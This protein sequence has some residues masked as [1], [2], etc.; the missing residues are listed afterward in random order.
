MLI[1]TNESVLVEYGV[2]YL[3]IA[4]FSYLLSRNFPVL[5]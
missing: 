5:F 1:F 4:C 2:S 3:R